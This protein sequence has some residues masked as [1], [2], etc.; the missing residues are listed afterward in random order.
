MQVKGQG[1]GDG[2]CGELAQPFCAQG[3]DIF[4]PALVKGLEPHRQIPTAGS[5][6][7]W[8]SSLW[9]GTSRSLLYLLRVRA[10]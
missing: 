9:A 7:H 4:S 8:P 3:A 1:R 2:C 6:S 10:F 5:P